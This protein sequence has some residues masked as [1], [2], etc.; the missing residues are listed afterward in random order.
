MYSA[1]T[2]A[3][4]SHCRTARAMNS[5][6]LSL[7]MC[8]GAPR[9][10]TKPSSTA[11]TSVAFMP[12]PTSRARHSRVYSSTTLSHF[13]GRPS[14]VRSWMKSQAQTWSRPSARR[15]TQPLALLPSRRRFL[16]LLGTLRP[17]RRH[18]RYTRLRLTRQPSARSS[19]QMRR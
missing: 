1:P 2:S 9:R 4:V 7:R 19:A 13:S 11:T 18:S 14:L 10:R 17:S 5:G 16:F 3:A 15:R 8:P 6:P 12:R